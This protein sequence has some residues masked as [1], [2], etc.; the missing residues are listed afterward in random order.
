[1]QVKKIGKSLHTHKKRK[2]IFKIVENDKETIEI[3]K[4][5]R[6]A[7]I[8]I[9]RIK[10]QRRDEKERRRD[11]KETKIYLLRKVKKVKMD[12]NWKFLE[13]NCKV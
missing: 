7:I 8:F 11:E 12:K 9:K 10:I 4:I 6:N 3:L 5:E 13:L 1:M 2:V